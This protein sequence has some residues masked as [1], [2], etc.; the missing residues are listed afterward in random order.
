ML[1]KKT[2]SVVITAG[3]IACGYAVVSTNA[4]A[5]TSTTPTP[6]VSAS[7][8]TTAVV[9]PTTPST[10]VAPPA[11]LGLSANTGI[12]APSGMQN[13]S[14]SNSSTDG[15]DDGDDQG[16]N[17]SDDS[18]ISGDDDSSVSITAG[19]AATSSLGNGGSTG[20]D[21]DNQGGSGS[22]D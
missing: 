11:P 4:F 19:V 6:T 7:A 18:G 12:Q 10:I 8:T 20:Q 9:A 13:P 3:V 1:N 22:N 17:D 16:T 21:E 2:I 14:L 15:D 5:D